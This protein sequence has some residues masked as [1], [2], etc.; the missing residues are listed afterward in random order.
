MRSARAAI[1]TCILITAAVAAVVVRVDGAYKG[2]A[3]DRDVSALLDTYPALKGGPADSCATC[4]QSGTVTPPT[5]GSRHE[6]HCDYC[7]SV[8]VRGGGDVKLT[9]NAFGSAYL[10]AGR[11]AAAIRSLAQADADGDG[12][13]NEVEL[14]KGSDPGDK[15]SHPGVPAAPA[16]TYAAASIRTMSPVVDQPVFLNTTKSRQGD[17]YNL[18]RGNRLWDVLQ[19][20]GLA[21]GANS[22]DMISL[23]GFEVTLTLDELRRAW[24]QRA[25]TLGLGP[26]TLGACGWVRYNVP[27]LAAGAPL[28]DASILLAFEENGKAL[29]PATMDQATGRIVGTGPARLVVPQF[30]PSPPDLPQSADAACTPKVDPAVRFNDEYDHNGGRS[31]FAIVAIRVKPLP[32]GTR[33]IDW[34]TA[35]PRRAKAGEIVI[36]GALA[37]K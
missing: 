2:H 28:P 26:D 6:N 1:V 12:A 15:A 33:D 13:T 9:L 10:A 31:S 3:D 34:Q 23:D 16:R 19:K 5:G 17:A 21:P 22:V 25:P 20:V 7:H 27:G 29:A 24:P 8:H 35:A 36:F 37:Q 11:G 14:L 30:R 18:Y 32:A 4:H